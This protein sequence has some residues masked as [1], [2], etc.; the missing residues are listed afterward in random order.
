MKRLMF[1]NHYPSVLP[2]AYGSFAW[3]GQGWSWELSAKIKALAQGIYE[4]I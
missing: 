3:V 1:L 4:A 2:R